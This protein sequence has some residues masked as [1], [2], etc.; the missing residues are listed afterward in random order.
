MA[1]VLT[2]LTHYIKEESNRILHS[3]IRNVRQQF[4]DHKDIK[5]SIANLTVDI[6]ILFKYW[7]A[8]LSNKHFQFHILESFNVKT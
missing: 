2:L 7:Q 6:T 3:K 5:K 4:M 1:N 8:K